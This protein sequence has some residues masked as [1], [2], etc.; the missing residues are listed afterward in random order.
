MVQ[1]IACLDLPHLSLPVGVSDKAT[2]F[3]FFS[4]AFIFFR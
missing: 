3:E 2:V 4:F 1:K